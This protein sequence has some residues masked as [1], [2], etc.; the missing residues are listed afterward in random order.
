MSDPPRPEPY[1]PRTAPVRRFLERLARLTPEEGEAGARRYAAAW[2]TPEGARADAALADAIARTGRESAR[3]QLVG[4]VLQMARNAAPAPADPDP[5][6]AGLDE[7]ALAEAA[8]A[9]ALAVLV[10]DALPP[11]DYAQLIAPFAAAAEGGAV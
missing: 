11:E 6:A 9:V 8:L 4:P 10:R 5:R 1:G 3:D 7:E 2:R